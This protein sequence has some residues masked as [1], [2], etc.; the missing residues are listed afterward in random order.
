MIIFQKDSASSVLCERHTTHKYS[1][2]VYHLMA[3]DFFF[4]LL[5]QWL[6]QCTKVLFSAI[7]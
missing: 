2:M 7:N 5:W 6:L 4:P 3:G 1:G